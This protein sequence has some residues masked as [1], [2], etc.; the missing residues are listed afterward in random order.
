MA[1]LKQGAA[2]PK[3][4]DALIVGAGFSGMYMLHKLR[5]LGI[6][7]EV[8]EAGTGVGGTWYW[9]R[10]PGARVDIQSLEYSFGFDQ[11]LEDEWRWSERYA[12]QP[13][14]LKYANHIAERF[15][16]TR[17]IRFNTRI[18][19]A[20]WNE[21][22]RRW[23]VSSES[24]DTWAARYLILATGCLSIPTDVT[25]PGIGDFKGPIYRT[26]RWP[27]EGVDFTGQRV[28]IIGTGSSAIQSIPIIAEQAA[29]LTV[30]QRTPNYSMPAHNGEIPASD[31]EAWSKDRRAYRAASKDTVGGFQNDAGD[32]LATE[33]SPE[34][35]KADLER[36]W[37]VGGFRILG[38]YVD[39]AIDPV[40]NKIVHD[41]IAGK[42]REQ[43][44]DPAI[45]E[46]LTPKDHPFGTKRPCVDTGY[47]KTF[48]RPNVELIDLRADPIATFNAGGIATEKR[49]HDFD[50]IVLA[51]G[52]DAMTGA[53][54]R[55]DLR[56]VDGV[57]IKDRWAEGP[58][59]YLGLTVAGFPNM[60]TITGPGSPS[61]LT[62]MI[63][64]I[65]QHVEWIADCLASLAERQHPS[66]EASKEAEDAWVVQV[67]SAVAPSLMPQAN[68]WYM[69][70]NV[71]GK[72]R[73]FM[74]YAGGLNTYTEICRQVAAKGYEGF[75]IRQGDR[76]LSDS[77]EFTSQPPLPDIP[78]SL[79]PIILERLVVAGLMPAA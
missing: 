21:D 25:F 18:T 48:N 69:G 46:L 23:D 16:L 41:F 59:T 14:L 43:V 30:F 34:E 74:P 17:D 70:A 33:T 36:R 54:D 7:A 39:Q 9:N 76:V 47:Y 26:S 40:A 32:K 65:E 3:Q 68:S 38:A 52:F 1:E 42:I 22:A 44:K 66:I 67:A 4:I 6:G 12:P 62:N 11:A 27:R 19:A 20:H 51:T 35:I 77:R 24:G 64:S 63:N 75:V 73:M 31:A 53:I 58:R 55:I 8:V 29:H 49:Q 2:A 10:Y 50:A 61:V 57:K 15:D 56:G 5:G 13:E 60:F 37:A 45:A 28:G 71:P 72:P 79:M 78:P